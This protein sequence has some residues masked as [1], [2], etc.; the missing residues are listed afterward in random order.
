MLCGDKV[1]SVLYKYTMTFGVDFRVD[2]EAPYQEEVSSEYPYLSAIRQLKQKDKLLEKYMESQKD[3]IHSEITQTRTQILLQVGGTYATK[4]QVSSSLKV[5]AEDIMSEVEKK[6]PD[7]TEM[8]KLKSSV[9]Q[10]SEAITAEVTRAKGQ[11]QALS[12]KIEQTAKSITLSVENGEQSSTIK[13][14][15]NGIEAQSR[16]IKFTG[17]MLF[18]SNLTDGETEISGGNIKTGKITSKNGRVYFDLENNEVACSRV[19]GVGQF[20]NV[21]TAVVKIGTGFSSSSAKRGDVDIFLDGYEEN[22]MTIT[23]SSSSYAEI[24]TKNG[25]EIGNGT[26]N[27]IIAVT[28]TAVK[29]RDPNSTNTYIQAGNGQLTL[30]GA[31]YAVLSRIPTTSDFFYPLGISNEG[32]FVKSTSSSRRYKH[33][34]CPVED[35]RIDPHRLYELSVKQYVFNRDYLSPDDPRQGQAVIGLIAEDV[36]EHYP[37]AVTRDGEGRIENWQERYILPALLSLV[38]EQHRE[39][40]ALKE[41]I[42]RLEDEYGR[43]ADK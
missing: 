22:G 14:T 38:Q 24:K 28:D 41:R 31:I 9:R 34:I 21:P 6:I 17:K 36:A 2:C 30:S 10:T 1:R 3:E 13:L 25:L 20:A 16:T 40:E 33:Q 43:Q 19:V 5:T 11:E 42:S 39:I 23:P 35:S 37:V 8:E 15:G 26:S 7:G 12:S 4:E 18:A 27:G 32:K 29:M